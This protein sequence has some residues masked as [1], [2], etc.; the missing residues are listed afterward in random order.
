VLDP[1]TNWADTKQVWDKQSETEREV[2]TTVN[3]LPQRSASTTAQSKWIQLGEGATGA[4]P[5]VSDIS[6]IL[7]KDTTY[8]TGYTPSAGPADIDHHQKTPPHENSVTNYT[9][10]TT[11]SPSS[12]SRVHQAGLSKSSR[13]N[14]HVISVLTPSSAFHTHTQSTEPCCT[15]RPQSTPYV[16][17]VV[18]TREELRVSCEHCGLI[19]K[20]SCPHTRQTN[21]NL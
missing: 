17:T 14:F 3:G 13:T 20:P 8:M 15:E 21:T 10:M 7:C 19:I 4:S 12:D 18:N 9:W 5:A 2:C 1:L 16:V 6:M 11:P